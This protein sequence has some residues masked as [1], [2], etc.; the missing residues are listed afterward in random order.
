MKKCTKLNCN[1]F[2][3]FEQKVDFCHLKTL[4]IL[5][6]VWW[7]K[8]KQKIF[9]VSQFTHFFTA[10][11]LSYLISKLWSLYRK[12][13]WIIRAYG[14]CE[15]SIATTHNFIKYYKAF[16]SHIHTHTCGNRAC[17]IATN[18]IWTWNNNNT[19][20]HTSP[21]KIIRLIPKLKYIFILNY[22]AFFPQM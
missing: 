20:K 7:N 18:T 6:F 8:K 21:C 4:N 14:F 10:G 12:C 19:Y 17:E 2:E 22:C 3:K 15:F 11:S 13:L 1:A 16:L 5:N 9:F